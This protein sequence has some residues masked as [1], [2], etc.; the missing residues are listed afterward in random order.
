MCSPN[1]GPAAQGTLP[2]PNRTLEGY[3]DSLAEVGAGLLRAC[4]RLWAEQKKTTE[5]VIVPW[6]RVVKVSGT[7]VELE[8]GI[9]KPDNWRVAVPMIDNNCLIDLGELCMSPKDLVFSYIDNGGRL[10]FQYNIHTMW[11]VVVI[12]SG[13]YDAI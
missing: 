10:P 7:P 3:C 1:I 2:A 9:G 11:K 4:K 12:R 6:H 13:N 5:P 8:M